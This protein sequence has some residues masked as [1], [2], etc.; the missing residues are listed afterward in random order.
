MARPVILGNGA[1]TV[2]I[3]EFGLIDDFYFPHVGMDN[4]TTSRSQSHL[5][6]VWLD[7]TFSWVNDG[8]WKISVDFE[9]DALIGHCEMT[10]ETLAVKL[11]TTDFVD[12]ETN[13]FSRIIVVHNLANHARSIKLFTH[14]VFEISNNGRADTALYH[15]DNQYILDYQGNCNLVISGETESGKSF[16]QFAVGNYRV[17]GKEGVYKD[18]EDGLLSSNPVEHG[19]VDSVLGFTLSIAAGAKSEVRYWV[20]AEKNRKDAERLHESA[21]K[22][23][24][25]EKLKT[26]KQYWLNWMKPASIAINASPNK[27]K[28]QI[29]KSLMIIKAH[30]D[31]DGGI[32]ASIDSSIY[33]YG[34]DYY[35]YVWPRDGAFAI[36]PLLRLGFTDEAKKFLTFC[37]DVLTNEGYLMHKYLPDK[38]IGST[39]HPLIHDGVSELAIQ[40]DETAIII[41]MISEYFRYTK[42]AIFTKD[43]YEKFVVPAANFLANFVDTETQLPHASYDLWEQ[44]FLTS[45]YTTAVTAKALDCAIVLCNQFGKN[46]STPWQKALD[47]FKAKSAT[48]F[49]TS[50]KTFIKGF[51]QNKTTGVIEPDTTLDVSSLYGVVQFGYF[52]ND[53]Y[54]R[55]FHTAKVLEERLLD[56]SPSGGM[57]RYE[58]DDYFLNKKDLMGNPWIVTTLWMAQFYI[59]KGDRKKAEHY[60]DWCLATALPSGVFSEQVDAVSKDALSVTPLVW[61]HAEFI[62]T[63]LSLHS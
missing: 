27:Y 30:I 61:S 7:N 4:L 44:K 32:I 8:S 52:N 18:A 58:H 41:Y 45:T 10:N 43:M 5:L 21:K 28:N 39:W 47:G 12:S 42:D 51:L 40:E 20:A 34:R 22:G 50:S 31:K 24:I 1:L 37:K 9:V 3:N 17:E 25:E 29:K 26:T 57:P 19:G 16:D 35:S 60:I 48:F 36:W 49:D 63:I 11:S 6:G 15:P 54:D 23:G 46:E 14:Q 56:A 55:I 59:K 62:T 33:N 53:E 2:G 38:A 13:I